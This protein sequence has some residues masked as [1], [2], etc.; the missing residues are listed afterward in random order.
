MNLARGARLGPYEV[1]ES[2]G[3]GGMGVVYRGTDTRLGREVAI[4]VLPVATA[5]SPEARARFEREGR[6]IAALN[7]P[8]ICTL[9]DVGTADGHPYLVM[10][11]LDGATLH[12]TLAS[13]PLPIP[14]LIDHAIALADALHA[15]HARGIIHRDLK[16]AN[17]FVTARDTVKIL[18]FGL[19]KEDGD[20]GAEARTIDAALTGH[21]T[22]LGTLSYMSP[23]QL[24]GETLDARSDLFSLGLV[25]YEMATGKR[26]F[27]GK[28]TAEVSAAILHVQPARPL[29]V[30]P[31]LPE[32]LDEIILKALERDRDL[33]YQSAV[34]LRADLK[35]LKRQTDESPAT[36][37]VSRSP[38]A[39]PPAPSSS[40]AAL[41]V[42]LARRHPLAIV[43]VGVILLA[44]AGAAWWALG[45][46]PSTPPA[47]DRSAISLEALTL[48]GFV[49]HSTVS[50]DGRFIAYVRRDFTHSSVVVK[51]IGSNSDVVVM[52]PSAEANYFAP[53]I[54]PDGSYVDVL[55][56][57]HRNPAEP[58]YIVRV[59]L[60]GGTPRRIVEGAASGLGWS[61]D[62]RKIAFVR[63][64]DP[65]TSLVMADADGRNERVLVTRELPKQFITSLHAGARYSYAPAARP[66][67]S[68]D[69]RTIALGG[70][71]R[72]S[73]RVE[74]IEVDV[75]SGAERHVRTPVDFVAEAAYVSDD[76]IVAGEHPVT[77]NSD[78]RTWRVY[79]GASPGVQLTP[80]LNDLHG[81][82]LT[83]DRAAGVATRTTTRKTIVV[84]PI[85]GA[86]LGEAVPASIAG[87]ESA[88][89]DAAGN[90]FYSARVPGSV[91][92]FRSEGAHGA[93]KL[94]ASD[95]VMPVPTPDG[96]FVIGSHVNGDLVRVSV[97]GSGSTVLLKGNP[98]RFPV[99][100][101]P[102]GKSVLYISAES[103]SQ[104]PGLI[105]LMGGDPRRLAEANIGF[106]F[107]RVSPDGQLTIYP[108][109]KG[110]QLCRYPTFDQCRT[111]KIVSGP[112][113]ADGQ[114]AFAINPADPRNIIAQPID[115]RPPTPL[116]SFTDMTIE[117][118]SVSPDGK[119]IAITRSLRESDV[120]LIKGLR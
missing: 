30:R 112:F 76:T 39:T 101:T 111:L 105:P 108:S 94:V 43:G 21:G 87:P 79:R 28:T 32:K 5:A 29:S 97:D 47:N 50:R 40:D 56:D 4:K 77:T 67:W 18:D 9:F 23:E 66:A 85:A 82:Q 80:D 55:V 118:F 91:A 14:A 68:P 100:I 1:I 36:S 88:Q 60:L 114:T 84:G 48:D 117:D 86:T 8:N 24:R 42:G 59:P 78:F 99:A 89:L 90:L 11:L 25:L 2:L 16:P 83:A 27:H 12:Q 53:S 45:R 71:D 34:D 52:P 70:L 98:R 107:M 31:E 22:T 72:K 33:R 3:A 54:T 115:G 73:E 96:T 57:A 13:G 65:R 26:A 49:G 110:T 95:L 69:G 119:R 63:W 62:S 10:E 93:G 51:Q 61:P 41:A 6:A 104:Q 7:H 116:T 44:V 37:T 64:T 75:E 103:G 109:S 81:I 19:A 106:P 38:A 92:I 15:A 20:H 58:R 113:S 120:V 17:I 46:N 35:R 102:D 74:L